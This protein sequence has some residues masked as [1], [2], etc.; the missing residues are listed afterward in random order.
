MR[1]AFFTNT[2]LPRPGGVEFSVYNT[3]RSLVKDG[4]T[5]TVYTETE[6]AMEG[7][8]VEVRRIQVRSRRPFTRLK[9][10]S[11]MWRQRSFFAGMDALHFHDYGTFIHWFLPL[12]FIILKPVYAMTYHGFDSWPV[13]TKDRILRRISAAMMDVTFGVGEFLKRCY[14]H[15]IDHVFLGAPVRCIPKSDACKENQFVYVGRLER[16]TCLLEFLRCLDTTSSTVRT[17]CTIVIIG[18]GSLEPLIAE[19]RFPY[20]TVKLLP[21]Q[22]D[23]SKEIAE[24]NYI[25]ATGFL[26]LLEAFKAERIAIVPAFSEIR[27]L[28]FTS[29]PDLESMAVSAS[30][31]DAMTG[32]LIQLLQANSSEDT[33]VRVE[34][35]KEFVTRH[36]WEKIAELHIEAYQ[37]ASGN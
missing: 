34:R 1:I 6:D 5:L 2:Y 23:P 17:A 9:Y 13:R 3:C 31:E 7:E 10:W 12:R 30:D 25:V 20:L 22:L 11:W 26:A 33:A 15:R 35:A 14:N 8:G 37:H 21:S 28:Y 4:H 36:S 29:I 24:S 19:M 18:D 32:K 27:Q 16:D